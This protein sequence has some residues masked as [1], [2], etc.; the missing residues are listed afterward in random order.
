MHTHAR[1]RVC[2]CVLVYV[3]VRVCVR[4]CMRV[5][6]HLRICVCTQYV[7]VDAC[8]HLHVTFLDYEFHWSG[9]THTACTR[10]NTFPCYMARYIL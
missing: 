2:V 8:T 7:C 4:V 3:C 10:V 6:V 9:S 5:C 1:A